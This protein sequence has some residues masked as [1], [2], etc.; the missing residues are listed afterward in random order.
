MIY[1]REHARQR[2]ELCIHLLALAAT[3][4]A[5]PALALTSNALPPASREHRLS[6]EQS[7]IFRDWMTCIV[8]A[9]LQQGPT[10]RW[11]QRDCAG[12]VRFAVAEALR[13]HD[14]KWLQAM[15]LRKRRIPQPLTL[16]Q[17][18][19]K[20]RHNWQRV[21]GERSSWVGA[22]ELVQANTRLVSRDPLMAQ[23][24]DLFFF[25]QGDEQHLM[26]WMGRYLAYHTGHASAQDNGLRA[27][28]L[29]QMME[30]RDTR[31]KPHADNPNF[32]GVYRLN[33]VA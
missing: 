10:P 4:L 12:L 26:I 31:W 21:D 32:A 13:E 18:Q 11:L 23:S 33:F 28:P 19:S 6:P 24:G 25:D 17:E 27:Y 7:R 20:L 14:A 8:H 5:G 2:R 30:W 29:A 3:G 15:G 16:T 22:L 1:A 9:Q